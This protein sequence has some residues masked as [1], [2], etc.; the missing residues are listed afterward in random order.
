MKFNE[1]YTTTII[2]QNYR[3]LLLLL[4][5]LVFRIVFFYLLQYDLVDDT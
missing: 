1:E 3:D 5:L 2:F 4:S